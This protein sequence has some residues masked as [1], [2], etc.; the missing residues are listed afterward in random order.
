MPGQRTHSVSRGHD[1]AY[2]RHDNRLVRECP[3][4]G[5]SGACPLRQECPIGAEEPAAP[6]A[7]RLPSV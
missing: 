1:A 3:R 5:D 7:S 6:T 4:V 2:C